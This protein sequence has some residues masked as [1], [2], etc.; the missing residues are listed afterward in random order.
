MDGVINLWKPSGITSHDA[1]YK[2][3]RALHE[4]RV[5]HTGTLDPMAE[6]V[7][8]I[9][10]GKATKIADYIAASRKT[11][12]ATMLL[13]KET[14]TQDIT[15]NV[16]GECEKH[17]T[18]EQLADAVGAFVGEI[19]QIPPMYSAV[20]HN[21]KRLYELARSGIV[22]ERKPRK[23]TIYNI[24]IV[25]TDGDSVKLLVECSKGTYIRTLCHDIGKRMGSCA[26]MSELCRT[27]SGIFTAD[28]SITL[29][30]LMAE[31]EKHLIPPD[32]FFKDLPKISVSEKDE[33]RIRNGAA[34]KTELPRGTRCRVYS[35]TGEFLCVSES[36]VVDGAI[37]L[38]MELSFY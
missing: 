15:G 38:K 36:R 14:D 22:V 31:G 30:T 2:V 3:R 29:E 33:W 4:R 20:H 12:L 19:E 21:G 13:G 25:E 6:G 35:R 17:I 8:P 37:M 23:V 26:C 27:Q 28:E 11:Y 10:V 32:R 16:T 34:I 1:V 7:L 18:K 24:N 9:C 5:G